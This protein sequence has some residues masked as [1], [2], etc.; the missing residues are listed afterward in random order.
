MSTKTVQHPQPE[1]RESLILRPQKQ[2]HGPW[3]SGVQ[4]PSEAERDPAP[5]KE[6]GILSYSIQNRLTVGKP[7]CFGSMFFCRRFHGFSLKP[8]GEGFLAATFQKVPQKDVLCLGLRETSR[9][10][11][12]MAPGW[13]GAANILAFTL[14]FLYFPLIL[15]IDFPNQANQCSPTN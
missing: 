7:L 9:E 14:P 15:V 1:F 12:G 5:G 3:K 6:D 11:P 4:F 2:G 13:A 10:V 8:L